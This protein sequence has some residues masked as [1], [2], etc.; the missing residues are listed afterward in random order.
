VTVAGFIL[1]ELA[2]ILS[3]RDSLFLN[4][5]ML[6]YPISAVRLWQLGG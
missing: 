2:L 1:I 6:I 4:V 3:I 5:L